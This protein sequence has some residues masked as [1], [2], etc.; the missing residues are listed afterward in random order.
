MYRVYCI[1]KVIP[2]NHSLQYCSFKDAVNDFLFEENII[3]RFRLLCVCVC[4]C[5]CVLFFFFFAYHSIKMK[6]VKKFHH[7]LCNSKLF[8]TSPLHSKIAQQR[9]LM[10]NYAAWWFWMMILIKL[11]DLLH[12]LTHLNR[13]L[14]STSSNIQ[15]SQSS[16][17]LRSYL[18]PSYKQICQN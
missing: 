10:I 16:I 15:H 7:N 18:F 2:K 12:S 11:V 4:V 17:V 14:W 1:L 8:Q 5:V 3:K 13:L 9:S 6:L